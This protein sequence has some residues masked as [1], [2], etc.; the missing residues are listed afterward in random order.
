MDVEIDINVIIEGNVILGDNVIIGM[1]C[2]FKDC[3]IDD[4][5]IICLYS[6]IEGVMVVENCIVGFFI[7]LCFGVE[8]CND[9]Y[10]GNFVEV[11]NVCL[12]EGLKVN[13]LMYLG[14][15]EVG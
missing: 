8:L 12:G 15:V 4:N 5:M 1:G 14:D 11:K 9:V 7:C 6:V 3:E 13:Y 2:V 10:V